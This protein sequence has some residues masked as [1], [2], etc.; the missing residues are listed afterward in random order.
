LKAIRLIAGAIALAILTVFSVSAAKTGS[1]WSNE[2]PPGATLSA[3]PVL[4]EKQPVV[5]VY[6]VKSSIRDGAFVVAGV[7]VRNYSN[8]AIAAVKLGW[9]LYLH[10]DPRSTLASG[11]TPLLGVDLMAAQSRFIPYPIA[12]SRD[13]LEA[14]NHDPYGDFRFEIF[15]A[16]V[17]FVDEINAQ[18][19][20]PAA[21][22]PS[23]TIIPLRNAPDEEECADDD[24]KPRPCQNQECHWN[25]TDCYD[26]QAC[27]GSRCIA[28]QNCTSCCSY[29]CNLG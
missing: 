26:C 22:N 2:W 28:S 11:R 16:E 7:R 25:G 3:G 5:D 14:T 17:L 21:G 20:G 6:C 27:E 23:E 1:P 9:R 8:R 18:L 13:V 29:R 15:T 10:S 24:Q 4:G 12:S 19:R